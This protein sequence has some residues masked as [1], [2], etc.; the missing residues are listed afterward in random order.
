MRFTT[1]T[2]CFAQLFAKT[3]ARSSMV[4]SVSNTDYMRSRKHA[5]FETH[6]SCLNRPLKLSLMWLRVLLEE[7]PEG[8]PACFAQGQQQNH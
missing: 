6:M 3:C 8:S 2:A 7:H 4:G 1:R 5:H